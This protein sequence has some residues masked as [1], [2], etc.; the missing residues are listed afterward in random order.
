MDTFLASFGPLVCGVLHGFDR[1]RFRGC[2]R[3]LCHVAGLRSWLGHVHILLKDFKLCARDWTLAL[4]KAIEGPAERA[5]LYRFL[6][7]CQ[8]SKE[9]VALQMAAQQGRRDGLIAV[10]GCVEPCQ[11]MQVRGN[12]RTKLLELRDRADQVQA[13][14][15]LLP[16]PGLRAALHPAAELVPLHHAR[17]PQRPRLAGAAVGGGG[18]P[19]HQEGQLLPL[20]RRTSRRPSALADA[21]GR[22][23]WSALLDGWL[24]QSNPLA[25]SLLPCPVPYYWSVETAEYATDIAFASAEDLPRLYPLLVRQAITTLGGADVLRL[26]GL[27]GPPGRPPREDLAGEVTTHRQ[28]VAGG[29]VRQAPGGG[30]PAEDVRQVRP[31][32][33]A[34]GAAAQRAG[35]QGLPRQG[36]GAG[37]AQVLPA[38][39]QGCGGP[40]RPG[41][42]ESAGQRALCP[43][44]GGGGRRES[45][46]PN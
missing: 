46:W 1:L 5:G 21:Q 31:G 16:R 33:A 44:A 19:L 3:Q 28:G 45:R 30:Q 10:L 12:P 42:G 41:G 23:A 11:T 40:V 9:E 4:C 7:N 38:D 39:A 34:G 27:P 43:G 36:R 17:R 13:L 37:G 32:A 2:Q 14:L 6:N 15:P 22:T 20:G 35:L 24:R 8:D 18:H 29:D 25:G 26:P